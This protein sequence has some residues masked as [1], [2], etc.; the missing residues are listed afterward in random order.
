MSYDWE[1]TDKLTFRLVPQTVASLP[2]TM[3]VTYINL[4]LLMPTWYKHG[5]YIRYAIAVIVLV[6]LGGVL[7]RVLTHYFVLPWEQ[8]YDPERY[9]LETKHLWIPVRIVRLSLQLI[10]VLAL[11]MVLQLMQTAWRREKLLRTIEKEKFNVEMNLLKAQ[12]NPHFFFNTLN[13]IYAL[14]LKGAKQAP[15]AILRLSDLMQYMLYEASNE[16]VTIGKEIKHI[17]NYIGIEQMRFADR[18][19]LTFQSKCDNPDALVTPLL[20]LPLVE[21]AFKH[22]ISGG[23]GWISIHLNMTAGTLTLNVENS[24]RAGD[25]PTANGFGLA[26]LRKRLELAYPRRY[27]LEITE[28]K[29]T[30]KA[31]LKI[32]I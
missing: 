13:S 3:A 12:I 9:Q 22:G 25:R 31:Y 11:A 21:N 7:K 30:F 24:Y 4:Y 20:L 1:D 2:V 14:S 29:E 5:K 32:D 28:Q 27:T 8:V 26:N 15:E 10:P 19:E 6:F 17:Q 16:K 23:A 18:L